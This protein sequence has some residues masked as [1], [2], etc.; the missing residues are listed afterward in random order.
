[1]LPQ[2]AQIGLDPDWQLSAI[3]WVAVLILAL[4]ASFGW[5]RM[6]VRYRQIAT[7]FDNMSQ[8]LVMYDGNERLVVHNKRYL[9]IYGLSPDVVKPGATLI[10]VLKHRAALSKLATDPEEYRKNLLA[11]IA[12]GQTITT[13]AD[14]GTGRLI[15]VVNRPT[16][17]GGW[18]GTHED[19]TEQ[20]QLEKQRETLAEQESRRARIEAAI[21]TFRERIESLLKIVADSAAAM[22]STAT[23]L[24]GSSGQTSQHADRAVQ[25][26]NNSSENVKT[27]AIAA[28]ELSA[29][30]AEISRQLERTAE[31]VRGTVEV[32]QTTNAEIAGLAHAAQ[33]IGDVVELIRD[34][35]EQTNLLALN[36]TIEAA[37][38]GAAGKGFAVVA[39]E[40][41]SLAVQTGKATEEI[42]G[43]IR[44]VQASA[45]DAVAA[46][47]RITERM[48]AINRSTSTVAAAVEQQNAATAQ[49]LRNV[50][51]AAE[52][53]Q[54]VVSVLGEVVGAAVET[55]GSAQT[56]LEAAQ[57]VESAL[58]NLR[59]EVS[60]FLDKVAS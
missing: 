27:A 6:R 48:D 29:S 18:V 50:A 34:V 19:V 46:I 1:M 60:G 13:V 16:V 9:E 39:S 12:Q 51:G 26:S 59:T 35:A 17:G 58:T 8:G 53:A 21:A 23:A 37:R 2:L 55:R 11:K 22:R 45:A 5:Y 43:Q 49:I 15:S 7:A 36:A 38:A 33:K 32:S 25:T 20:R 28:E 41:K 52:G 42:A 40:V 10:E 44:A 47:R 24:F 31:E 54:V 56:V 3:A 4:A 30:I 57:S 14:S